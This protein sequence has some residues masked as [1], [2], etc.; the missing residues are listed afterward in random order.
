MTCYCCDLPIAGDCKQLLVVTLALTMCGIPCRPTRNRLL[1]TVYLQWFTCNPN[2][3]PI[4]I[5]VLSSHM[6]ILMKPYGNLKKIGTLCDNQIR[7][8]RV[9]KGSQVKYS[10]C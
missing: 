5:M 6:S 8:G 3:Y 2:C 10:A 4:E 9:I 7:I 1:A